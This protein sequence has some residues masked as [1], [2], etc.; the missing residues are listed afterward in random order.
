[1]VRDPHRRRHEERFAAET[2]L[3]PLLTL[4]ALNAL[5]D[6]QALHTNNVRGG[7]GRRESE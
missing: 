6:L 2:T 3:V 7:T 1:M 5:L 4:F